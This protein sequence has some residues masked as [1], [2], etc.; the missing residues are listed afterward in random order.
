VIHA[1]KVVKRLNSRILIQ[2][3]ALSALRVFST[4]LLCVLL[5]LRSIRSSSPT[6]KLLTFAS[7]L[8]IVYNNVKV[9]GTQV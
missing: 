5:I 4:K 9:L 8:I 6:T 3:V 7:I 1:T 2:E